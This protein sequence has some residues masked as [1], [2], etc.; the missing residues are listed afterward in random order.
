[1][2]DTNTKDNEETKSNDQAPVTPQDREEVEEAKETTTT[3]KEEEE[4]EEED[5]R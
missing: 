2:T 3:T 5:H 4:E 1:M